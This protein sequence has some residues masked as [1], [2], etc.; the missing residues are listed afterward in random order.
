MARLV[1]SISKLGSSEPFEL[2]VAQGQIAYHEHIYKFGQN[3]VVGNSVETI[4]Q[5]GGLYS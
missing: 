2:Q 1:T 4:W 5:Q 3:S